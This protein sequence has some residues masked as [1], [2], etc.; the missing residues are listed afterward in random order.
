MCNQKNIVQDVEVISHFSY[1]SDHRLL[2]GTFRINHKTR[3]VYKNKT[4]LPQTVPKEAKLNYLTNLQQRFNVLQE[5]NDDVQIKYD[6][7]E[8]SVKQATSNHILQAPPKIETKLKDSTKRLIPKRDELLQNSGLQEV[9][10]RIKIFPTF[11]FL[12]WKVQ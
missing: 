9:K 12:K 8:K 11:F 6:R 4:Y 10:M 7:F 2:R 5:L 1:K 3:Q